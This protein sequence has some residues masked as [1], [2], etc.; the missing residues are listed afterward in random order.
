M[1]DQNIKFINI[2]ELFSN[3]NYQRYMDKKRVNSLALNF[4]K[5]LFG[6]IK[7][8]YDINDKKYYIIDGQHRTEAARIK[9]YTYIPCEIIEAKT[10][11][12]AATIFV[13]V[14]T[15]IKALSKLEIFKAKLCEGDEAALSLNKI[16][17]EEGYRI[18]N[19]T[20]SYSLRCI[21]CLEKIYKQDKGNSLKKLL[22]LLSEIYNGL[23]DSLTA[24]IVESYY[25]FYKLY[26]DLIIEKELI[27]KFK[28]I[29]IK[30]INSIQNT[31]LNISKDKINAKTMA[32][33]YLYN[34][35]RKIS[36]L[37][38]RF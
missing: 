37:P 22:R 13:D 1:N 8:Y 35:K 17:E 26:D 5:N 18:A 24:D 27:R 32:L 36:I 7:V 31:Y 10:T 38:N 23:P 2:N 29:S 14:N 16:C 12:E 34:Y 19:S 11:K 15:K 25:R 33:W 30:E 6:Y 3:L 4:D 21:H 20:M 9:G 28:E